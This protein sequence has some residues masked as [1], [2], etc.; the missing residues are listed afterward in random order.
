[1]SK[2]ILTRPKKDGLKTL[3]TLKKSFIQSLCLPLIEIKKIVHPKIF[4]SDYD[5]FLFTSKNGVRN[6]K[7][8]IKKV[9]V[10]QL[11]FAVGDETKK[12]LVDYGFK[13]VISVNGNLEDLKKVV[14]KYLTKGSKILHPTSI[15]NKNLEEFFFKYECKYFHLECYSTF[16]VNKNKK[17]FKRFMISE[18]DQIITIYSSLTAKSFVEEVMKLNLIKHCK[19]KIFIVMSENVKNELEYLGHCNIEIAKQPNE[20]EMINL[21]IKNYR[22]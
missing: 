9:T 4:S 19:D 11:I 14:R 2:V 8:D 15:K 5:V 3:L 18:K 6:F 7:I 17:L 22:S 21:I 16:K 12:L 1:M 13:N 20:N 10:N